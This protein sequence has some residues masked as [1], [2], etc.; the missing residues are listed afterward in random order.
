MKLWNWIVSFFKKEEC[1]EK[2][3]VITESLINKR[4]LHIGINDYP[5][6]QNDLRGCVNDAKA[7]EALLKQ[8]GYQTS[9]LLDNNATYKNVIKEIRKLIGASKKGDK[10]VITFSGH[11]TN[12]R[13]IS[14]DEEDQRDEALVLFDKLLIDDELRQLLNGFEKETKVTI[15]SDSCHSGTVTRSFLDIMSEDDAPKPRYLPPEDDDEAFRVMSATI[16]KNLIVPEE[17]MNEVLI[18]GC[19]STEYS[20]D[21][22]INGVNM[23]AMSYYATQILKNDPTISYKN[24]YIKL[25]EILPCRRFPQT[26]QLEGSKE[27]KE[28]S[29]L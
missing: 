27:N 8:Q 2:T 10:A 28:E 19:K 22:R 3:E 16:R 7:W 1:I 29:M 17:G 23:G 6:Q 9:I 20:Y 25:R 15:I 12:I 18:T 21:A 13:D 14:G 24:F 4:S 11:G 5:G 26:P